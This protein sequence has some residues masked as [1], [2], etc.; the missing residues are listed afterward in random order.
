LGYTSVVIKE[1]SVNAQNNHYQDMAPMA[2]DTM[3]AKSARAPVPVELSKSV[4]SVSVTGS[5][6]M[7]K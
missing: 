5:L 7:L 2:A 1:I 6:Q 3:L 4:V